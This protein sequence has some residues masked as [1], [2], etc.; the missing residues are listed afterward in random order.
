MNEKTKEEVETEQAIAARDF[1]IVTEEPEHEVGNLTRYRVK[2]KLI[3]GDM[4]AEGLG[5]TRADALKAALLS[6]SSKGG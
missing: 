4:E 5:D 2:I 1:A 3:G 6:A